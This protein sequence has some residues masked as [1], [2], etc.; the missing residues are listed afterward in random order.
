MYSQ[1][2]YNKNAG[3]PKHTGGIWSEP[4]TKE[5]KQK[6]QMAKQGQQPPQSA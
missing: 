2:A 1:K 5:K 4:Q 3:A 6:I